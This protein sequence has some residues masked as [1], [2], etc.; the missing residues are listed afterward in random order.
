MKK[1]MTRA[2]VGIVKGNSTNVDA[3]RLLPYGSNFLLI[4]KILVYEPE[5]KI[6]TQKYIAGNEWYVKNV[7][8]GN[9]IMPGHMTGEAM[10]QTCALFLANID[11]EGKDR[12]IYLASSKARFLRIV[13][14]KDTLIITAYPTRIL[15][16][17]G[18]FK[19]EAR[20]KDELVARGQF[21]LA[22][23]RDRDLPSLA[24]GKGVWSIRQ[25]RSLA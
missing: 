21:T 8:P 6:V 18:I 4:D 2:A 12:M 9:P 16:G 22:V 19:A 23:E 20:V 10:L 14:P 11:A 5:Y 25:Y 3:K 13:K 15:S 24:D 7:Y 1:S 17:K